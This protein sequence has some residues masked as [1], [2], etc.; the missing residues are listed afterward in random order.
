M[1]DRQSCLSSFFHIARHPDPHLYFL[2]NRIKDGG[3][4]EASRT[5]SRGSSPSLFRSGGC[6]ERRA[7]SDER[8]AGLRSRGSR[9]VAR[10]GLVAGRA[11]HDCDRR[12]R[13]RRDDVAR[14]R[15]QRRRVHADGN[16]AGRR[17]TAQRRQIAGPHRG[18][19]CGA[20]Q[21][22]RHRDG[23]HL[24]GLRTGAVQRRRGRDRRRAPS[25]ARKLLASAADASHRKIQS[26]LGAQ[27]GERR[28]EDQPRRAE[29]KEE[30]TRHTHDDRHAPHRCA[31]PQRPRLHRPRPA[32]RA[33]DR[34]LELL[35]L[36][37]HARTREQHRHRSD[38]DH[39]RQHRRVCRD[40]RRR[41]VE[42][43]ELLQQLHDLDRRHRRSAHRHDQH[44]LRDHRSERSQHD[45]RRHR[46]SQLRL[47]LDGQPGHSQIDERRRELDR[48]RSRHL[49]PRAAGAGRPVPAI[50][51]RR[52]SARRS[53][54]QQQASSPARRPA[55]ISR[56]TAARTGPVRVSRTRS[57]RCA[58]TSPR[59]SSRTW[60]AA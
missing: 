52:Q 3:G 47:V 50:Q 32:A 17:R 54:Q 6:R 60:A 49:R 28:Q 41:R 56:T 57:T 26:G 46:R 10:R 48:P 11:R 44:R 24:P 14:D 15:G 38:D 55:S 13:G 33:D 40:R 58:R 51:R 43:H 21:L 22:S 8:Q 25:R 45:L 7:G 20:R 16:D 53:E 9:D 12:R 23:R 59:S 19:E 39:E 4:H 18:H 2:H 36:H 42:D 35:Q 37:D 1:E 31:L 27:G 30:R 29:R 5:A 34:L